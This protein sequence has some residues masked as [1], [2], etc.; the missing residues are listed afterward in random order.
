M[1]DVEAMGQ[2][3]GSVTRRGVKNTFGRWVRPVGT[4]LLYSNRV[5]V[6]WGGAP[7]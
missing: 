7:W 2:G 1:V 6:A 5:C 3:R 4:Y